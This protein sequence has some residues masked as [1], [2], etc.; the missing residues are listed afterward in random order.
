VPWVARRPDVDP[1]THAQ[2][3]PYLN[4]FER[5][6]A[7]GWLRLAAFIDATKSKGGGS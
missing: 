5:S 7:W 6:I 4:E 2:L 1:M 3:M